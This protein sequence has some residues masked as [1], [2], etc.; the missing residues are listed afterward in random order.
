MVILACLDMRVK[1]LADPL[2]QSLITIETIDNYLVMVQ[3]IQQEALGERDHAKEWSARK[4]VLKVI[5][6][7]KNSRLFAAISALRSADRDAAASGKDNNKRRYRCQHRQTAG[8]GL[9]L[10]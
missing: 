2:Y 3:Q 9:G 6:R 4:H 1:V 5:T 10:V 7:V 8:S